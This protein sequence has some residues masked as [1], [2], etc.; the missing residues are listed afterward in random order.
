MTSSSLTSL[1]EALS[2]DHS[3]Q[4]AWSKPDPLSGKIELRFADIDQKQSFGLV[5]SR[6][7]KS[8][9]LA[10]VADPFASKVIQFL[11]SHALTMITVLQ[12]ALEQNRSAY[13]ECEFTINGSELSTSLEISSS[14][15]LTFRASKFSDESSIEFGL[16]N[17]S[18]S[19]LISFAVGLFASLLPTALKNY[20]N[21]DE[22]L[23]YP[24]GAVRQVLVNRYERD[25]RNRSAA[26]EIHGTRCMAC[27]FDFETVYGSVGKGYIVIHHT[28]PVSAM[29]ADYEVDPARD[30]VAICANC[31]AMVHREDPPIPV[32]VLRRLVL[33]PKTH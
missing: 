11:V 13:S 20:T 30:L 14:P 25:P 2:R 21:P 8:T 33:G 27:D 32:E 4:I 31:H 3:T 6:G 10:F 17:D 22:V 16:I 23:G 24:E 29:G 26:I 7:W 28:T 15:S 1:L 9:E 18:E 19:K 12:E 5:L